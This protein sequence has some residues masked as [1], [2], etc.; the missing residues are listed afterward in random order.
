MAYIFLNPVELFEPHWK[1]GTGSIPHLSEKLLDYEHSSLP[2]FLGTE[3]LHGK[4]TVDMSEYYDAKPK[5]KELLMRAQEYYRSLP[6][7]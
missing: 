6:K 4:I 1:R 5:L 7:D 2:D 3:R